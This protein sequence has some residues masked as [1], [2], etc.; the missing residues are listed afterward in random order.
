MTALLD[1]S[2]LVRYLTGDPP[3]MAHQATAILDQVPDL[4]ITD[5]VLAETAYVLMSRYRIPRQVI[6]DQLIALL[7]KRNVAPLG[8][9]KDLV[10]QALVLC[11]PSG[12]VAFA[13]A[14]VWAAA[15]SAGIA[16]VYSFDIRFPSVG[17]HVQQNL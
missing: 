9:D 2:L 11:R 12:R 6:V 10:I 13:D 17:I 16:T 7:R 8:L 1:T 14:L 3:G 15:H 4:F 5:V